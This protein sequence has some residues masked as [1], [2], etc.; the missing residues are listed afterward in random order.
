MSSSP[1]CPTYQFEEQSLCPLHEKEYSA[2]K[3]NIPLFVLVELTKAEIILGAFKVRVHVGIGRYTWARLW[4]LCRGLD[5]WGRGYAELPVELCC[6]VLKISS[7]TLYRW[8][9]DGKAAGAFRKGNIRRGV[10]R[11]YMSGLHKVCFKLGLTDWAGVV[12]LRLSEVNQNIRQLVTGA[13]TQD[14]QS[15]SHYAAVTNLKKRE[16]AFFAPPKADAILQSKKVSSQKS[17][18]GQILFLLHVGEKRAFVSRSFVPFGASQRSIGSKLGISDRTVRRHQEALGLNRRQLMQAKGEYKRVQQ[19]MKHQADFFQAADDMYLVS[20]GNDWELQEK[21]R[22]GKEWH[23]SYV[24]PESFCNYYDKTWIYRCNLYEERYTLTSMRR[25]RDIFKRQTQKQPQETKPVQL[26]A[27]VSN[28]E[29]DRTL[30]G[31]AG[32]KKILKKTTPSTVGTV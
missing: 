23:K 22:G 25:S 27:N 21:S 7:Q 32:K 10:L 13:C 9:K 24:T 2:L 15:K 20:C 4:Y 8:L 17:D 19:A 11:I 16:R 26:Y 5:V 18:E 31:K 3:L 6:S 28:E 14:L 12:D 1:D 29:Y 30:G